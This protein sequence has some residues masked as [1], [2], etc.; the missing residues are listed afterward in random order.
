[1]KKIVKLFLLFLLILQFI[2][3]KGI[4]LEGD[5]FTF[6]EV[7]NTYYIRKKDYY[8]LKTARKNTFYIVSHDYEQADIFAIQGLIKSFDCENYLVVANYWWNKIL[9]FY[10]LQYKNI[11]FLYSGTGVVSKVRE[12]LPKNNVFIWKYRNNISTGIYYI[13]KLVP[14]CDVVLIKIKSRSPINATHLNASKLTIFLSYINQHF[15]IEI[16]EFNYIPKNNLEYT[17]K[18]KKWLYDL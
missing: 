6:R 17:E 8:K 11:E 7:L 12:L 16:K 1:M 13:K 5:Y 4:R 14:N 9:A 15:D 2:S 3:N 18:Y 10:N